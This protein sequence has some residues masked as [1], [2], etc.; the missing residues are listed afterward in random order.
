MPSEAEQAFQREIQMTLNTLDTPVLQGPSEP[1]SGFLRTDALINPAHYRFALKTTLAASLAYIIYTALDW[2]DIHTAMVTCYVAALGSTGETLHKLTL[3]IIGCLIG[4][5]MGI[6]SIIFLM[7]YMTSIG[8]LMLLVFAGILV[9]G[10]VSSGSERSAY[11]GV[12]IGLAFL[13]TVLQGFGPDVEI[14]VATDRVAGILLGNALLYL[15][16]TKVWPV[17]SLETARA[18]MAEVSQKLKAYRESA[19]PLQTLTP[20]QAANLLGALGLVRE[21]L[22]MRRFEP[23]TL[24][25]DTDEATRLQHALHAL[26]KCCIEAALDPHWAARQSAEP[27]LHATLAQPT[28]PRTTS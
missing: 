27:P 16:F 23:R 24:R 28:L 8:E 12:Q 3:R 13:L 19:K 5:A 17:S 10:W 1:H 25:S 7:P 14:S 2:Q 4:A 20:S 22:L 15:I 6:S 26:E 18:G 21:Q 11:A 9:A